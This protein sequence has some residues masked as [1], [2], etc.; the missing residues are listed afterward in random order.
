MGTNPFM[1]IGWKQE[2]LGDKGCVSTES[3]VPMS[4]MNANESYI[5]ST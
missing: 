4:V 3:E 2:G 1:G 5:E